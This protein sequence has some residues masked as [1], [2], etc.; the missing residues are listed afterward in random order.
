[1]NSSSGLGQPSAGQ[2][3]FDGPPGD[4]AFQRPARG[5]G[6]A[7]TPQQPAG[8]PWTPSGQPGPQDPEPPPPQFGSAPGELPGLRAGPGPLRGTPRVRATGHQINT[9]HPG[10]MATRPVR[11]AGTVGVRLAPG[12]PAVRQPLIRDSR[13]RA[14]GDLRRPA[15]PARSMV[16][17]PIRRRSNNHRPDRPS[18][19][20][21]GRALIITG[22][23]AAVVVLPCWAGNCSRPGPHRRPPSAASPPARR[24]RRRSIPS[25]PWS[26]RREP[27]AD[28]EC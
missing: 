18:R 20:S 12:R 19:Q 8:Q 5:Q 24:A 25:R 9:A 14:A 16:R 17:G 3:D 2:P 10:P 11:P 6:S 26:G 15:D 28:H 27:P 1:M 7:P 22:A 23:V 4:Q 13:T 21:R